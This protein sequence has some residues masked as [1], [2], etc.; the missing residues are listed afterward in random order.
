MNKDKIRNMIFNHVEKFASEEIARQVE[1]FDLK[2]FHLMSANLLK[3]MPCIPLERHFDIYKSLLTYRFLENAPEF[4]KTFDLKNILCEFDKERFCKRLPAIYISFHIGAYRTAIL[5]MIKYNMNIVIIVDTSVYSLETI[6][7]ELNGHIEFAKSYFP[8]SISQIEILSANH[9]DI[10]GMLLDKI[11]KGYSILSYIDW[12]TDYSSKHKKNVLIK[13]FNQEI[14][15]KQSLAMLSY[16][17]KLPLVPFISYYNEEHI[18]CWKLSPIISPDDFQDINAYSC[19]AMQEIYSFL[20]LIVNKYFAQWNGWWHLHK[21]FKEIPSAENTKINFTTDLQVLYISKY[22]GFFTLQ[23]T[24]FV[25][26][27]LTFKILRLPNEL[28]DLI[29]IKN[30]I[31]CGEIEDTILNQLLQTGIVQTSCD[32]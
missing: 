2:T 30:N 25:I 27:K 31:H 20:E 10:F 32:T 14:S 28:F 11:N 7:K 4:Y 29:K 15:V 17:T 5:P 12:T 3:C 22:A 6:Q 18:P 19:F 23:D 13:F 21:F 26:N 8:Q 16:L 1:S 24:H 9:P